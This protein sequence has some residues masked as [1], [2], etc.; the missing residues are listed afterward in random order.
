MPGWMKWGVALLIGAGIIVLGWRLADSRWFFWLL[1]TFFI[2]NC[3]VLIVVV[4]LQSGKAAHL[5]GAFSAGGR[6]HVFPPGPPRGPPLFSCW[7]PSLGCGQW[8]KPAGGAPPSLKSFPTPRR[9][10][11]R[12]PPHLCQHMGQPLRRRHQLQLRRRLPRL[13]PTRS[14]LLSHRQL[15]RQLLQPRLGRSNPRRNLL[16][17]LRQLRNHRPHSRKNRSKSV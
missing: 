15:P 4:L 14:L 6:R 1:P 16:R 13:S 5:P 2:A 11:R 10:P 12:P 9:P 8:K 3:L 17:N 7:P